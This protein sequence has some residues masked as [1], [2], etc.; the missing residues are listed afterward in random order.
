[1]AHYNALFL[2]AYQD[3]LIIRLS[4][5]ATHLSHVLQTV[6]GQL[7]NSSQQLRTEI[8]RYPHEFMDIDPFGPLPPCPNR[9][10][11]PMVQSGEGCGR[12]LCQLWCCFL[13]IKGRY[14]CLFKQGFGPLHKL[15]EYK[16]QWYLALFFL[17]LNY[18]H[19]IH[20]LYENYSID[21]NRKSVVWC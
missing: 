4:Y 3:G 2:R 7:M 19:G 15:M 17:E 13:W 1:M 18:I 14:H 5:T 16:G 10:D 21:L 20:R 11:L 12:T 6:I 8:S 9:T